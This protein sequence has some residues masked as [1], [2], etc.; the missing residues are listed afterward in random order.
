[1]K[2]GIIGASTVGITLATQFVAVGHEVLVANSRGRESLK[3][4]LA[5]IDGR[6][7][8]A[9]VTEAYESD[10]VFL[11][12]PW[13][14]VR[15]VL[16]PERDWC[17]HILVDTTNIFLSYAPDF[18]VDDLKGDSGSE[19]V[20]RLAPSARTVKAFNTLPFEK[21]FAPHEPSVR[22][23]LFLAGD[24]PSAV[25]TVETLISELG[26]HPIAL[27]SLA[28]AGR[29]MELNG[30]LNGLELLSPINNS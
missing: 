4:R 19:I 2:I 24:D 5:D 13:L 23:V 1:M 8:A 15:D 29:L 26:L 22:R 16:T 20:S 3:D 30:P 25:A 6:L 12:V 28:V 21:I 18:R 27:G 10:I 11:A 17:G 9:S 14:K 7:T